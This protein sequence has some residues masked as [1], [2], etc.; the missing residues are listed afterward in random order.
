MTVARQAPLSMG[1]S[2]QEYWRGLPCSPPGDLS[3]RGIEPVSLRSPALAG[4]F[5]TASAT[6]EAPP[7]ACFAFLI[8]SYPPLLLFDVSPL[9]PVLWTLMHPWVSPGQFLY[10]RSSRSTP[11]PGGAAPL[12]P[13]KPQGWSCGCLCLSGL[14][15][16][17][18]LPSSIFSVLPMLS[19]Y[20]TSPLK[21]CQHLM[22]VE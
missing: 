3:N 17:I 14:C 19:V 21:N 2:R 15:Q 5:L 11:A 8:S 12:L 1:A 6:W 4:R 18:F 20:P 7:W 13:P 10:A 9:T 22:P 16:L